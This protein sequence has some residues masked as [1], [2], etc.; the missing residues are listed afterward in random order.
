MIKYNIG[1][2][3]KGKGVFLGAAAALVF[4]AIGQEGV[5]ADE[6]VVYVSGDGYEDGGYDWENPLNSIYA[7]QELLPEGGT[8]V[9]TGTFYIDSDR[10]YY[11]NDGITIQAFEELEGP[12][13]EIAEGGSLVLDNMTIVGNDYFPISNGGTLYLN[14]SVSF[15]QWD[16]EIAQADG[17]DTWDGAVTY[18][19]GEVLEAF[20]GWEEETPETEYVETEVV[21][22]TEYVEAEAVTEPEYVETEA[23]TE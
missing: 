21:T 16:E 18:L 20:G 22:E 14:D 2:I 8:I 17:V 5:L 10:E 19:N 7:A 6:S 12:I 3:R 11:L 9:V 15:I 13:F 4:S 23:V 1:R